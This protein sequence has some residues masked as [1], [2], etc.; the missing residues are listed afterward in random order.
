MNRRDEFYI[1]VCDCGRIHVE[2]RNFRLSFH[3][4]EF[5]DLL[6]RA[7]EGGSLNE[8][9]T[10]INHRVSAEDHNLS[11][12]ADAGTIIH[13]PYPRESVYGASRVD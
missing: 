10:V 4:A 6:L 8:D 2:S 3:P 9:L 5:V 1:R 7:L 11:R 12:D 13:F